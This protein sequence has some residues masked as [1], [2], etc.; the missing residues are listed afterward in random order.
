MITDSAFSSDNARKN[1]IIK[2]PP[3]A[4]IYSHRRFLCHSLCNVF[5]RLRAGTDRSGAESARDASTLLT[6]PD[7]SV[8]P[9]QGGLYYLN[10]LSRSSWQIGLSP[11]ALRTLIAASL[12]ATRKIMQALLAF[13]ARKA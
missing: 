3:V 2:K 7:Y 1:L 11:L 12:S 4:V 9:P 6:Q 13:F 10:I 8:F 5:F